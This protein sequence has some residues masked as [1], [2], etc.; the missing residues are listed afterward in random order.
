[1]Q[2]D[3]LLAFLDVAADALI[4]RDRNALHVVLLV[5]HVHRLLDRL[6]VHVLV[7]LDVAGLEHLLADLEPLLLADEPFLVGHLRGWV[8]T[9]RP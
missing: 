3:L 2:D 1:V 6:D 4:R 8:G 7:Q 5:E 9:V